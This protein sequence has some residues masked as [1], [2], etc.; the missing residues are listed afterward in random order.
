[1]AAT[2]G[3]SLTVQVQSI[4]GAGEPPGGLSDIHNIIAVRKSIPY[5]VWFVAAGI[6]IAAIVIFF[7]VRHLRRR[8]PRPEKIPVIPPAEKALAALRELRNSPMVQTGDAE[9]FSIQVSDIIRLYLEGEWGIDALDQTTEETLT[10]ISGTPSALRYLE[11]FARFF[12]SCDLVKFAGD[13]F[14]WD[15]YSAVIDEAEDLVNETCQVPSPPASVE[16]NVE[17]Q[18][19]TEK[20]A[21]E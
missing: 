9:K 2:T 21:R 16:G 20:G 17:S 8:P 5:W 6:L 11:D 10:R 15:D 18:T 1:M 3:A 7:S 4:A 14:H 12:D 19:E 13:L